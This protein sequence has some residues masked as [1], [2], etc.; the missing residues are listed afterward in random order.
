MDRG[1]AR[2]VNE[3]GVAITPRLVAVA[4]GVG[5]RRRGEAA[6]AIALDTLVGVLGT[7]AGDPCADL[8]RALRAANAAVWAADDRSRPRGMATTLTAVALGPA[9]IAVGH[10]GD[11][12]AYLLRGDR[13]ERLTRDHS[14]VATLVARGKLEPA[15]ASASPLRSV[16]LRALGLHERVEA[17]VRTAPADPGDLVLVCSDGLSDFVDDRHLQRAMAGAGGLHELVRNLVG[18]ARRCGSGDDL[19]IAVARLGR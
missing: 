9:G 11:S 1:P 12:R 5:G 17:T 18:R 14:L 8:G 3:D 13:L 6:S 4:D 15:A 16:I 19:S 10:V 7:A 2:Q